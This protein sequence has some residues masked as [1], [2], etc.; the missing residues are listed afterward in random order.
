MPNFIKKR[1]NLGFTLIE[2]LLTSTVL[3]LVL[4]L[5]YSIYFAGL[6][7]WDAARLKADLQAQARAAMNFMVS[8]LRNATRTSSQNP[9]PNASIPST[10]NNKSMQFHLPEDKD[11]DGLITDSNG[12]TEWNTNDTIQYQYIPGQKLLRRL[13]KGEQRIL[14]QDVSDVQFIDIGIDPALYM[15]EIKIILTLDKMTP[16]QRN[17]SIILTSIVKL[18]N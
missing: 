8:E 9:S 2:I 16:K 10:P 1:N 3:I 12:N 18:R 14:S 13:E 7:A 5:M 15:N 4:S 6:D 17:I 11:D